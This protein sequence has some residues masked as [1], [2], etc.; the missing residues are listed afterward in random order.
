M[1]TL[2]DHVLFNRVEF[3]WSQPFPSMNKKR[4]LILDFTFLNK[5]LLFPTSL[6][7]LNHTKL[8]QTQLFK[9]LLITRLREK[10][11]TH[12]TLHLVAIP[13][14]PPPHTGAPHLCGEALVSIVGEEKTHHTVMVL[15]GSHV[16]GCEAIL[17]L[18]IDQGLMLHQHLHNLFLASWK[19][20]KHHLSS[21]SQT[22]HEI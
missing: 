15:L 10:Y 7:S 17:G 6:H 4:S 3:W 22:N 16:Q 11:K 5:L 20:H 8:P 14:A 21:F 12:S 9:T 1:F 18:G 13:P 19:Y 2:W